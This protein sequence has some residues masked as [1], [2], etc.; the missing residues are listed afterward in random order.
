MTQRI[1]ETGN[2]YGL[3]I[4]GEYVGNSKSGKAMYFCVCECGGTKN[5]AGSQYLNGD[6]LYNGLD[7][8]D[9]NKG[10]FEDNVVPCC[11][12]CNKMKG[13][14]KQEEFLNLIFQIYNNRISR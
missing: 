7:R 10:Y 3:L 13:T 9:N 8:V 6:Y 4:V 1:D 11:G 14:M 5:V 12:V 2:K